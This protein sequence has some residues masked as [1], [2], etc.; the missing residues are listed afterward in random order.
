MRKIFAAF[1]CMFLSLAAFAAV[2]HNGVTNGDVFSFNGLLEPAPVL[3]PAPVLG[4]KP[5]LEPAP[6]LSPAPAVAPAPV[7]DGAPNVP[8]AQKTPAAPQIANNVVQPQNSVFQPQNSVF[9]KQNSVMQPAV[10]KTPAPAA[11]INTQSGNIIQ[12]SADSA[13]NA[14]PGGTVRINAVVPAKKV[15]AAAVKKK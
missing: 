6:K 11:D 1:V 12:I 14:V 13:V 7:L 10:V 15:K 8:S 9:Q 4:P 3:Q 5:V 2:K